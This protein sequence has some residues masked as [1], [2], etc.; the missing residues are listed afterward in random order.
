MESCSQVL[1]ISE[2]I[3]PMKKSSFEIAQSGTN[4]EQIHRLPELSLDCGL[5]YGHRNYD[6][7]LNINNQMLFDILNACQV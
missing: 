1:S 3:M 6:N 5:L 4:F 2:L 7:N